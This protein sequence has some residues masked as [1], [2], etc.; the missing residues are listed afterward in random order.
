MMENM[1]LSINS[2]QFPDFACQ[3][4]LSTP[5]DTMVA[6][7]HQIGGSPTRRTVG[8]RPLN[9]QRKGSA[10]ASFSVS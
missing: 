3:H 1:L 2:L 5:F 9:G 10:A 8:E 7:W 4:E 6:S